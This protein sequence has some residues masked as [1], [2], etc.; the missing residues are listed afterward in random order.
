MP[1]NQGTKPLAVWITTTNRTPERKVGSNNH[2][3]RLTPSQ[4]QKWHLI[5]GKILEISIQIIGY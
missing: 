1:K 5:F 4:N 2:G 3:L